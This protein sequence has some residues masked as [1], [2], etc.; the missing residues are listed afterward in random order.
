MSQLRVIPLTIAEANRFVE[1]CHRH[2]PPVVSAKITIG[3]MKGDNLVGVLIAG[4]PVARKTCQ[5]STLEVTRLATDGTKNAC[6]ILYG[7][8]ARA[9]KALGYSKIQTFI[10]DIESGAS[11]RASGWML[12][13]ISP[14]K[15]WKRTDGEARGNLHPIMPKIRYVKRLNNEP[16]PKMVI[17]E[18]EELQQG[19]GW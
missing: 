10:L 14:G 2:H 18:P 4:R 9:A 7:A 17:E 15:A 19:F 1:L 8:A 16:R 12:D 5:V 11:L 13:G 3:A 6:S